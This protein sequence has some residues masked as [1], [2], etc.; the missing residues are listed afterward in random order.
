M[1]PEITFPINAQLTSTNILDSI[2]VTDPGS[3]YS[4]APAVIITGGGGSGAVAE[5]SI[6]NGRIDQIIVKDPGAGYSSAPTVALKSSF[7]YV[8]NVDLG[9]LQLLS[10]G[11]QN[12]A[13]VT[14]NVVDTGDGTEFPL[15]A[16][17]L[18]RLTGT[19]TYY[20]IAGTANS[21]EDDQLKLAITESNA[22]LG[23]AIGFVNSNT[24]RQQVL[25][26]SFGAAAE[27]N[28]ITSTFLEGELVYQ[29]DSF[30]QATATG[31]VSTNSGWQVGP[32][33]I[34]IV[35]YTGDFIQ[36]QSI[37]GVISKSSGVISDLNIAKGVLEIG[38]I[39]KT[40]GQFIDDVGKPSEI[41]QK[42]QD[43]Y[44]YQDF[45][46]AVQ[47]SVSIDDWKE[48]LIRNAHPA[49][50]KVFGELNLNE[51]SFI[52][53]K[54]T[55]FELTK[56]VELTRDAIIPNVQSFALAEPI[57][58]EFNN[59]EVLFRQKRLTSSENILTS[60]VQRLDDVSP[61]FD[62]ERTAFPLTVNGDP[63]IA[64]ANQIL[65]NMNG[66]AQ[67]PNSSFEVQ[68]DSIVFAEP[69]QPPASVKY[70]NI[71]INQ[72]NTKRF[73]VTNNS[74]IFPLVGNTMVGITSTARLTVTSVA[75]QDI[76]GYVTEGT[77][78]LNENVVVNATGF[79]A[80]ISAI[81]DITNNGL[82]EFNETVTNLTGDIARVEQINLETGQET[83]IAKLRYTIGAATTTTIETVD[84]N[85][86]TNTPVS[87]GTFVLGQNYQLG[88]EI[89]RIDGITNN[90]SSTTIQV[91]RAQLGTA[92][93]IS[94]EDSPFC[95]TDIEVTDD[96][97]LV[98]PHQCIS[99]HSRSLRYS[100][101]V[102]TIIGAKS[103]VVAQVTAT[104][105]YQDPS[106]QA[107]IEQVNI[108]DGSSFFGLLF[109]N[110][111]TSTELS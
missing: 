69:P 86:P 111:K 92:S 52:P 106:T 91:Q 85:T 81:T 26:E 101:G 60:V 23:D 11:I 43:S 17:A 41:I 44:Y 14:L 28:V 61:L 13:E 87:S 110:R 72:I 104:S 75:G 94:P 77:F 8:I 19:T 71:V 99:V 6:K 108:S 9:L 58:S 65:I 35:D 38:S 3:G 93:G 40:T 36:G 16:G 25:T 78:Q 46:Y 70:V 18:G 30:A 59:T 84:A 39:T 97:L 100:V 50:F 15:A 68:G 45:S 33:I 83:P 89:I 2:T 34:K 74:G 107:F 10:H 51:Y 64:N 105:A 62:G 73:T 95:G 5:A 80:Q 103:G 21:L 55:K 76:T 102:D 57:Y 90:A 20:A 49:S 79:N 4:Q 47:S 12:G 37:T 31:Y 29:G 109:N 22:E 7:N 53:N 27:A 56:S 88:S 98:R 67:T 42:I 1:R 24:G 32:R 82:F 54:E 48:I 96:L 66:V 63:V